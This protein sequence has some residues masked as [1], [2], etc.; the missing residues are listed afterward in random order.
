MS[1]FDNASN[2]LNRTLQLL[3]PDNNSGL[4]EDIA[5]DI[6]N[7]IDAIVDEKIQSHTKD[8]HQSKE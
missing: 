4:L 8:F 6:T 5:Y 2:R 3:F 1:R 7:L